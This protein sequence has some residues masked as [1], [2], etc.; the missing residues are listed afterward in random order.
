MSRARV[1]VLK[2]LSKQ[3]T[4]AE[5][6][7]EVGLSRRHLQRL[8]ARYR[9]GG[10]E[11]GEPRSRRPKTT[12]NQ[13]PQPIRERVIE[14]RV[15]LRGEGLDAGPVTIAW[16]LEQDGHRAPSTSTIRRILHQACLIAPEPRK[17]PRSSYAR[18]E[19]AQPNQMWQSD[20]THWRLVDGT[21][22]E[23]LNWLDDHSRYL[24]SCTAHQPVG[25]ETVVASF[26]EAVGH[27][28]PPASTLTDNASVY[29]S[30]FTGGRN[31][32]EYLLAVLGIHQK[33]GSPGH[34]QT[35]GKIERFHQ[36]LK[37]W[38]AARPPAAT[39]AELQGQLDTF[40]AYYNERRPHRAL[41]RIT[42]NQA[43]R[44]T[45]QAMP[46]GGGAA[47]HYRVRYDRIDAKGKISFRRAGRMHHLGIGS[48]HARKRVMALADENIVSVVELATG[49]VL[50]THNIDPACSY[51]RNRDRQPGRWPG[52]RG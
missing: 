15:Q 35:Q 24:L 11:A 51:W 43:Y 33:N 3:A 7:A 1:G 28:G 37:R 22:V 8:L 48:A 36:T 6:A 52:S 27:H 47:T 50:S 25:G 46:A 14:L 4:V 31:A 44:A 40:R 9:E 41:G 30:R 38:L 29:T 34:P 20:C 18:F 21:D 19:A 17:R 13:T 23:I 26:L 5:A 12:P 42:P 16:H 10:L 49:E 32:F 45:P 2:V 39:L